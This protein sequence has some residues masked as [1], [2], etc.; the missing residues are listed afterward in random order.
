MI[1]KDGQREL[2][3]NITPWKERLGTPANAMG[4]AI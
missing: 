2:H 1:L 3:K 4:T